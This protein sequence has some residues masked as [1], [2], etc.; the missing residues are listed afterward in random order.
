MAWNLGLLG[1]ASFVAPA[2]SYDLLQTEIL[3]GSQASVTF[4]SL[5]D[6]AANYQHLQLRWVARSTD[7]GTGGGNDFLIQFNA[8]TSTTYSAH[9]LE[10]NGSTV[11]SNAQTSQPSMRLGFVIRDGMTANSYSAG[12]VDILDP[13]ETSKNTTVRNLDG[14]TAALGNQ[15][16]LS[17]GLFYKTESITS[18]K[19]LLDS[20]Q[21]KSGSRFSLYGLKASV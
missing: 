1:A 3:T 5:G 13:F 8:D 11:S 15:I 16:R 14:Y 21:F 9:R 12:V 19:I 20:F 2:G 7:T 4:S 6:Y 18:L 10:G 17:S